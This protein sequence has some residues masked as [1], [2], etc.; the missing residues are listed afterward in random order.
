MAKYTLVLVALIMAFVLMSGKVDVNI[1]HN[2]H[3]PKSLDQT[4][5]IYYSSKLPF[6]KKQI[7][8]YL[9]KEI[10]DVNYYHE[11]QQML[12]TAE[13]GDVV[14]F[15]IGGYGGSAYGTQS[16]LAAIKNTKAK[17]I[18]HVEAPAHSGH[19]YIALAPNT[20]LEMEPGTYIMIHHSGII[21]VDCTKQKG[22]D[23]GISNQL[24]CEEFKK[25]Q[26]EAETEVINSLQYL[27]EEERVR[28]EQGHDVHVTAKQIK[29]RQGK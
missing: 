14:V 24:K 20:T 22:L 6:V 25:T 26:T 7:D 29:E 11:V 21:G 28:I 5:P 23:R 8:V 18:M 4:T 13:K 27:T 10:K 17:V 1:E 3:L 9:N 16:V 19:G 12:Y 15:H 2:M